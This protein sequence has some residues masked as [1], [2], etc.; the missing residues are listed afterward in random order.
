[1]AAVLLTGLAG[2]VIA[3]YSAYVAVTAYNVYRDCNPP[4]PGF[5]CSYHAFWG[6]DPALFLI[7]SVIGVILGILLILMTTVLYFNRERHVELGAIILGASLASL[8]AFGGVIVGA[9]LGSV[10]GVLALRYRAR[11]AVSEWP[12]AY[13]AEFPRPGPHPAQSPTAV[14]CIPG[15]YR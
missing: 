1:M 15:K 3:G 14:P 2:V 13:P 9:V 10:G 11:G 12:G 5:G 8:I 4:P 7:A 6:F